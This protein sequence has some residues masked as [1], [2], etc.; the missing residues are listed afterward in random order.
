MHKNTFWVVVPVFNESKLIRSCLESFAH[1]SDPDFV[2][3]LVDNNS[4]DDSMQIVKNFADE[5]PEMA[6]VSLF[7][8][9]KGIG[10]ACNKGFYYAIEQ[11]AKVIARTDSDS[12]VDPQWVANIKRHHQGG[13]LLIGGR[14]KLR[15]DEDC[16]R[17]STHWK[18]AAMGPLLNAAVR[19]ECK[20]KTSEL[21][22][23]FRLYGNNLA[24]DAETF[25]QCG[26]Y[27]SGQLDTV[28]EDTEL[29]Y[30]VHRVVG[31]ERTY[32]A[33]DVVVFGSLRR[34]A[35][36]GVFNTLKWYYN[37]EFEPAEI[38]IR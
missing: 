27:V 31:R 26:G 37:R 15:T 16:Y 33:K 10:S 29:Q 30:A 25:T 2:L 9:I 1:Q 20:D 38:D 35:D 23:E 11:G 21:Y 19:Q 28:S 36:Y 34:Y 13:A 18:L 8:E 7:E 5:H 12:I 6:I 3:A 24:V 14:L 22:R 32:Y 17:R 4:T